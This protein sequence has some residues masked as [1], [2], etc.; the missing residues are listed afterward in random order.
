MSLRITSLSRTPLAQLRYLNA[1]SGRRVMTAH[2]PLLTGQVCGLP[3]TVAGLVVT[4]DLQGRTFE[5]RLLG[6]AVPGWLGDLATTGQIPP[7]EEMGVVLCGDLYARPGSTR[8][9]GSGD[10]R[11]I[12]GGFTKSARWVVG[13]A[14]NHDRLGET[15]QDLEDFRR[16]AGARFLDGSATT[17]DGLVVAGVSGVVGDSDRPWRRTLPQYLTPLERA[18]RSRPDVLVLHDGPDEPALGGRGQAAIREVL[19]RHP[20]PAL[21]C[22]GHARWPEQFSDSLRPWQ[23]LNADSIVAVLGRQE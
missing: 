16:S 19:K 5:D 21:L 15:P 3:D 7:L 14:G 9:G 13:V 23:V 12:W 17:V 22:R 8:R 18:L 10:V 1:S 4:S 20:R 2:L 11:E 6:L